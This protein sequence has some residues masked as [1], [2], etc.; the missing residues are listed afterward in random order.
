MALSKITLA[1]GLVVEYYPGTKT[2]GK[3]KGHEGIIWHTSEYPD[4]S[5]ASAER[6]IRD[7]IN[8]QPGSYNIHI[9]DGG[10]FLA[11]P[12]LEASG[13]INPFS[14]YWKPETWMKSFLS[15]AAWGDPAAYL[16]QVVFTGRAHDIEAGKMPDN[17]WQTAAKITKWFEA[18]SWGKDNAVMLGHKN[19]QTNRY[20]PGKGTIEKIIQ[21]YQKLTA[22]TVPEPTPVKTYTQAEMDAVTAQLKDANG[23]IAKLK[24]RIT[25]KDTYIKSYPVG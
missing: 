10:A 21:V 16:M 20:D 7:Q 8:G 15:P 9:F 18:S 11:V 22:P 24:N 2:F 5:R 4:F 13:G 3:R 1:P 23:T 19:F 17:M 12:Y 14:P 25:V 6:C